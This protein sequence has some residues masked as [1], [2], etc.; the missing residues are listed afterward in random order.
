[1]PVLSTVRSFP[2]SSPS[3]AMLTVLGVLLLLV[4]G[5]LAYLARK[6]A[7]GLALFS[8]VR[9]Y[10]TQ[11]LKPELA[12]WVRGNIH[13]LSPLV[14]PLGQQPCVF[15]RRKVE[16]LRTDPRGRKRW[17]TLS[18]N[19]NRVGFILHDG[20]PGLI[21][22]PTGATIKA[23]VAS[24]GGADTEERTTEWSLLVGQPVSCF[25]VPKQWGRDLLM[26]VRPG[27]PFLITWEER[28]HVLAR[29]RRPV[30]LL[31]AAAYTLAA[32]GL[33]SLVVGLR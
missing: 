13:C 28:E 24:S 33:L 8:Q 20:G 6:R 29:A 22:D 2:L 4:A 27:F 12:A 11:E 9:R 32:A 23:P 7:A 3:G 26:S 31:L 17:F 30:V 21:V 18:Q 25:G 16:R 15:H 10:W 1:M 14:S 5:Y 19:E